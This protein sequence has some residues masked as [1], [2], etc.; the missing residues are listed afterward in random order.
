MF[1]DRRPSLGGPLA[2]KVMNLVQRKPSIDISLSD[3]QRDAFVP[4]YTSLDEIRGEVSI[5]AACDTSFDE[6]Y[7]TFDGAT[8]TFVEKIATTSPT[9]SRT[10]AFHNFIRLVQ[11]MDDNA[12]LEPRVLEGGKTYK[13][14]FTFVVP[15]TLLPQ[16]C[17]HPKKAGFPVG[18]HM[19]LPPS[20]GDPL[21]ASMGKSLMDDMA[22]DMGMIAYAI[23]CRI[24]T[25]RGATGRHR[26]MVE[27]SK[28]L[29]IIP[30][31]EELPPLDVKGGTQDDY[32][33]RREKTIKKGTFKGKLGRIVMESVQPQSLRLP[34]IREPEPL[35]PVTTLATVQMRFD[36]IKEEAQ[37]P[38]L[39]NLQTKL[40]V[41][42]F[43]TSVPMDEVPIRSRDFHYS[44]VRGLFVKTVNLSS[45]SLA[46]AQWEKQGSE[47]PNRRESAASYPEPSS[48]Y[49]GGSFY[50]ARVVV[51]IS[52][53]KGNKVFVPSFH[54]CLVSR[55]YALD[56]FLAVNTPNA[57]VTDPTVHL[58]L[59]VQVSSKGNPHQR[60]PIS[61]HE[62]DTDDANEF[63]RPRSVAPP[64]Q[65][66]TEHAQLTPSPSLTAIDAPTPGYR[67]RMNAVQPRYQSLSF[68]NEEAALAP[69]PEY[70]SVI[71]RSRGR[72]SSD[73]SSPLSS[74]RQV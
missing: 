47:S 41:A 18:A 16:S 68:E 20:L 29:R 38:G 42:T 54:S 35:C 55:I 74:L 66:Y 49:K 44:N 19:C 13:L 46:N 33:L 43:F 4:S 36:P 65:E 56:L 24:T 37:P 64:I 45:R 50:T 5:T 23:K 52:L 60:T 63:F 34:S 7:I 61:P 3:E 2:S 58:K 28:K 25:G 6:I 31:T 67:V 59:P 48:E 8:K 11:P 14:P 9:N 30:A 21:V 57:T 17:T 53:P 10:E 73:V 70:A 71:G 22:P 69:P 1:T 32:R 15:N 12:F 27:G 26:I 51:P 62:A 72:V 40:K 39:Q